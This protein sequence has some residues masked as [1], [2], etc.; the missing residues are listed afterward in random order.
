MIKRIAFF[1][2]SV[3]LS[4]V[5]SILF[6]AGASGLQLLLPYLMG[7]AI[8]EIHGVGSVDF[9]ALTHYTVWMGCAVVGCALCHWLTK[10][11]SNKMAFRI[12][13][14][15]RLDIM[16]KLDHLPIAYYDKTAHGD[17]L[18]VVTN[19]TETITEGIQNSASQLFCGVFTLIGTLV[20]MFS[21]NWA[22]TLIVVV[23]TPFAF[24]LS[25]FIV[26]NID[27]TFKKQQ[28]TVGALNAYAKEHIE[29]AKTIKAY[30]LE[31]D[32]RAQFEDINEQLYTYGQK[33]QFFSSL[34][35]PTTRLMNSSTYIIV[36]VVCALLVM[37]SDSFGTE[38]MTIGLTAAFLSYALQFAAPINAIT[39]VTAQLQAAYA[40]FG[41][42]F[43]IFDARSEP[44]EAENTPALQVKSG[45]I[46]FEHVQ[47][48]YT[49]D[50]PIIRDVSFQIPP[51]SKVA[52][53]GPTGA[54]KTTLVNLLMRFY[55]ADS[56]EIRIDG[57]NT[58]GVSRDSLRT[59]FAMVLQET[60]LF[61]DSVRANIAYAKPQASE[62]EVIKAAQDAYAHSFIKRLPQGYDTVISAG[63]EELSAGQKQLLTI[64]R[65]MLA[66]APML[67]L[68]E[69]TSSVDTLTEIKIQ[70]AFE[71][72]MKGKTSFVIA[73]RLSTIVESDLILVMQGGDIVEV[74]THE[75][76]L[77]SG[78][79]YSELYYA[80]FEK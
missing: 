59:S 26:K 62:Q 9:A 57:K 68:D 13:R 58:A 25:S 4:F 42:I 23:L 24:L 77:A 74:G 79:V 21:L 55:D 69:A 12:G 70:K 10:L 27:K 41:R 46:A 43:S 66:D 19:D 37:R 76:L 80:Q 17:I 64:A 33:A 47:F 20:L 28:Q 60:F 36:G 35:N 34:V 8:D 53:V 31:D 61:H 32:S 63:G 73:H 3:R 56:G 52:V 49:K 15:V 6:A 38:Q 45:A 54:G 51:G 1:F 39:N 48:S 67:I 44:K 75:K 11:F 5:C 2:K 22:I 65:A 18:S 14:A 16:H 7:K 40:S 50:K 78:G 30:A 72:L 71:K 29:A